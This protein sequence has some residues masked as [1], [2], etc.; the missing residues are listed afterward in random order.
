VPVTAPDRLVGAAIMITGVAVLGGVA[1]GV[2]LI[3]AR[4]VAVGEEQALE[5]EAE[6][7][8]RRL[9]ARLES[10]DARLARIE[11]HL[12]PLDPKQP[13]TNT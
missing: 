5:A 4:A 10:L 7:V 8:E 1:A 13:G 9:E 11:A 2:A 12:D 3:V 6:S